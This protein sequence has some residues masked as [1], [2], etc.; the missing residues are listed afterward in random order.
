MAKPSFA[1]IGPGK[2]GSAVAQLLSAQNYPLIAIAGREWPWEA[3]AGAEIVL[4]TTPDRAIGDV[5]KVIAKH[6]GFKPGMVVIHMSGVLSSEVLDPAREAGAL[7]L[8]LHP[9]QSFARVEEAV[10][11]LP[12]SV[13]TLEGD[14]EALPV[15][16]QL[17]KDL[18][19]KAHE[20]SR[21]SKAL[22]HTAAVLTSN[23]LVAL[24]HAGA[25]LLSEIGIPKECAVA[26]LAPLMS[27]VLRNIKNLGP[28]QALTG[29]ISRGDIGTVSKHLAALEDLV[30]QSSDPARVWREGNQA[31]VPLAQQ[32][33]AAYRSLG[34]YTVSVALEKGSINR[35]TANNLLATLKEDVNYGQDHNCYLKA[36]ET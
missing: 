6:G 31:G 33:L 14:Q 2:V 28:A 18:G 26:A 13:F 19:G 23:Y 7:A 1:V 9:L 5:C 20:I 17:V 32:T 35:K 34:T 3:V 12:G 25:N 4:I 27:G 21:E 24:A 29:P 8:S 36:N 15:G 11:N 10:A 16:Y 30:R 22:Y